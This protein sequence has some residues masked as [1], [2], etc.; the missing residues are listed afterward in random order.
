MIREVMVSDATMK[1]VSE[2]T[3]TFSQIPRDWL[4]I[5]YCICASCCVGVEHRLLLSIWATLASLYKTSFLQRN[6]HSINANY[7]VV[8]PSKAIRFSWS[9]TT[10]RCKTFKNIF[11]MLKRTVTQ[12]LGSMG[13]IN[14]VRHLVE[15]ET[16]SSNVPSVSR[17]RV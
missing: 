15:L 14:N 11:K 4:K 17:L 8:S 3:Q 10:K 1:I 9:V 5:R 13:R 2:S 7:E 6:L 12:T 16:S